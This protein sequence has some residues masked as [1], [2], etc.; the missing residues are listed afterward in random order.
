ME[1]AADLERDD[2]LRPLRLAQLPRFAHRLG[3]AGDHRLVGGVEVRRHDDVSGARR[4]V[5]RDRDLGRREPQNRGHGAGPLRPRLVHQLAA[6]AYQLRRVGGGERAGRH[7][8]R[9]FAERVAGGGDGGGDLVAH[10]GEH[11]RAVR[12]DRRLR[13]VSEGELV[14]G[15]CEHQRREGGAERV[16][17][18]L[19]GLARGGKPLRQILAHPDFLCALS[20]AQ[21]HRRYHR[22][23]MLAQVN[24]A[25]NAT[26]ITVMP[27]FSRPVFTA[28]SSAMAIEAADVL[29]KRSTLTYTLSI[30]TPACFAVASM[31]RM[32]A[33]CGIRRSMSP[34]VSPARCSAWSHASA[35]DSTAA[36]KTSRPAIL[37]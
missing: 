27:A 15:A 34:A 30:G 24:P 37:M 9:V 5:A 4:L 20:R 17:D 8:R 28:S 31:M 7:V 11:R 36:L 14:F 19:E 6:A 3:V 26:N 35:I 29:P 22:T 33:W 21:P 32:F 12:E 13:I 1:R 18:R 23:T 2:A 25:P 16:V 10:D